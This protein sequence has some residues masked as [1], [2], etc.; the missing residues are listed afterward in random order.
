MDDKIKA[1]LY[2]TVLDTTE[3]TKLDENGKALGCMLPVYLA[4]PEEEGKLRFEFPSGHT[5]MKE[6]M[7]NLFDTY[8]QRV[9][10]NDLQ[11]GDIVAINMPFGLFH[12]GVYL[13]GNDI[14]HCTQNTGMELISLSKYR[15][16]IERGYRY[17]SSISSTRMG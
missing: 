15:N 2:K 8:C 11:E 10:V 13:G 5:N 16:R 7:L 6:Y 14:I 1:L 12:V 4:Y 17:G 3:Y 9:D